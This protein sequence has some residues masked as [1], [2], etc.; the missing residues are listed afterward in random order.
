[1]KAQYAFP[2]WLVFFVLIFVGLTLI[3]VPFFID[4]RL[5][6]D[7][8]SFPKILFPTELPPWI[9]PQVTLQN[10]ASPTPTAY[11]NMAR[12]EFIY[13]LGAE[14]AAFGV[15]QI[16]QTNLVGWIKGS[17]G[18]YSLLNGCERKI[19]YSA[20]KSQGQSSTDVE[21]VSC[22][23]SLSSSTEKDALSLW[24]DV[25]DAKQTI[26]LE[27]GRVV[28]YTSSTSQIN[29]ESYGFS[30]GD[31]YIHTYYM[32]KEFTDLD[33]FR[34]MKGEIL[35]ACAAW[36][37]T[38]RATT[39][40]PNP[41]TGPAINNP[42]VAIGIKEPAAPSYEEENLERYFDFQENEL[43]RQISFIGPRF[44]GSAIPLDYERTRPERRLCREYMAYAAGIK[45]GGQVM[46]SLSIGYYFCQ[47]SFANLTLDFALKQIGIPQVNPP[48]SNLSDIK[49]EG[50][51][52][53]LF[54]SGNLGYRIEIHYLKCADYV[55]VLG[56]SAFS[57]S[58]RLEA[59]VKSIRSE[60]EHTCALIELQR[61]K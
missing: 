36:E 40:K 19:A 42:T 59:N 10:F 53:K 20:T 16:A 27:D 8:T 37:K 48:F 12:R 5:L 55:L 46:E 47:K 57:T 18:K 52:V 61:A 26:L 30:C 22:G 15:S 49:G 41:T 1:M 43:E 56:H 14:E 51:D 39:F 44:D 4:S 31:L 29:Y 32:S 25:A 33:K 6:D 45:I 9:V 54:E 21:V 23:Y 38:P 28:T 58:P 7:V 17:T 34:K 11:Q 35:D 3:I 2:S 24:N 13:S 60:L 50:R